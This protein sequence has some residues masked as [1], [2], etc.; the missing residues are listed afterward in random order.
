VGSL[1]I[2][3]ALHGRPVSI[4]FVHIFTCNPWSYLEYFDKFVGRIFIRIFKNISLHK[5]GPSSLFN[6]SIL[7]TNMCTNNIDLGLTACHSY[8]KNMTTRYQLKEGPL[9]LWSRHITCGSHRFMSSN[10]L[11]ISSVICALLNAVTASPSFIL[12]ESV[13]T[14]APGFV[15]Q[16]LASPRPH[17]ISAF[18]SGRTIY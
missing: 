13:D 7:H 11:G 15:L 12:Y 1:K 8:L 17:L 6:V 10:M 4:L 2:S 5:H 3:K 18:P 9:S 16:G 14:A